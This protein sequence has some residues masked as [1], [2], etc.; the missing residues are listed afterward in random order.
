MLFDPAPGNGS[1]GF[2]FSVGVT[3]FTLSSAIGVAFGRHFAWPFSVRQDLDRTAG[4]VSEMKPGSKLR[5]SARES[6]NRCGLGA[7]VLARLGN[8]ERE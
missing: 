3:S 4:R 5:N 1:R 6:G 2:L 8:Q 7:L